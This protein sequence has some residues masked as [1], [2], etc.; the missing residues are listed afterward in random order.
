MLR[1]HFYPAAKAQWE[2]E[3]SLYAPGLND[4]R[5]TTER[6]VNYLIVIHTAPKNF[7]QRNAIRETWG[8]DFKNVPGTETLFFLGNT[9]NAR[10]R[11]AI[12]TERQN[13]S[14]IVQGNFVDTYDNLTLKSIAML[15]MASENYPNLTFLFKLDDDTNVNVPKLLKG[16]YQMRVDTIHGYMHENARV[17]S[18]IQDVLSAIR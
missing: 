18:G 7:E 9:P 6:H 3:P 16:L 5:N 4:S 13:Y 8:Q 17:L 14:D 12:E 2:F 11:K 15:K 1:V 10:L